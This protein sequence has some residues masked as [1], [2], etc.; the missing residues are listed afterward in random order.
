[1]VYPLRAGLIPH[2]QPGNEERQNTPRQPSQ[3]LPLNIFSV[4][5]APAHRRVTV[6]DMQRLRPDNHS[7]AKG[8]RTAQNQIISAQ[9]QVLHRK[10]IERQ[11]GLVMLHD[12]GKLLHE[13]GAYI[14][15]LKG[16]ID[17]PGIVNRSIEG[18]FGKKL[19]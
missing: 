13:R 2:T 1:M 8:A 10:G 7:L 17:A 15:L 12:E 5:P 18:S 4:I 6:T 9:I 14:N 16:R 3:L 19:M 11:V